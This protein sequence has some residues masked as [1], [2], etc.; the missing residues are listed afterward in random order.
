M[1]VYEK[2]SDLKLTDK[3]KKVIEEYTGGESLWINNFLRDR[4]IEK[5]P[6]KDIPKLKKKIEILNGI[7]NKSLPI[8]DEMVVYRGAEAMDQAWKNLKKGDELIFTSTGLVSTSI[9]KQV[10]IE[11]IDDDSDG[12][13]C[14]LLVLTLPKGSKCIYLD[15]SVNPDENEIL[16]PH[17]SIFIVT[18]RKIENNIITYHA[19]LIKQYDKPIKDNLFDN[20]WKLSI[21]VATAVAISAV[22]LS[23]SYGAKKFKKKKKHKTIH[24]YNKI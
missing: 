19:E 21:S 5:I 9:N 14:C 13:K 23:Q 4:D 10:S 7:I 22:V 11:F 12:D 24:K 1:N 15:T 6:E 2:T 16:L 17:G 3:E 18:E 20:W 8:K